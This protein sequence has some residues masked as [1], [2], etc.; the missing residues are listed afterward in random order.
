MSFDDFSN[1]WD[2]DRRI[3]R[4]KLIADEIKKAVNVS[5]Q[6]ALEFG[7]GT[8]LI[9]FNLYNNFES[10][11][12]ADIS[13]G[14]MDVLA[15]KIKFN[16]VTNMKVVD[17]NKEKLDSKYDLIYSSMVLHHILDLDTLIKQFHELL[18]EDGEICIVDLKVVDELF[19][20]DEP[21]FDG[22]HGIDTEALEWLLN[23]NGFSNIRVKIIY[24]GIKIVDEKEI[25]YSL[26]L[27][28][29]IKV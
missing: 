21:D 1:E 24:E 2:T 4:A 6:K 26:F 5:K 8:G 11:D 23:I 19:H 10:I 12:L 27:L 7:C 22:H 15:S 18:N 17:L 20:K 14:M 29:A 13:E 9:S 16:Q 28:T 3:K 25:A